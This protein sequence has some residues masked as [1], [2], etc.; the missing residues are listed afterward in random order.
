M[1]STFIQILLATIVVTSFSHDVQG[2]DKTWKL[3]GVTSNWSSAGNWNGGVPGSGDRALIT[4][5]DGAARTINYN[6]AG[7]PISLAGTI[8]DLTGPGAESTT[9]AIPANN[10]TTQYLIVGDFGRAQVEQT[11][12]AVA[13]LAGTNFVVGNQAGSNGRYVLNGG[14]VNVANQ[15][16]LGYFGSGDL[17]QTNGVNAVAGN[18]RL[19]INAGSSGVYGMEGG[20]LSAGNIYIGENGAGT[21]TQTGGQVIVGGDAVLG[22]AS[23]ATSNYSISAGS[24]SSGG[25]LIVGGKSTATFTQSGGT[26]TTSGELLLGSVTA[27]NAEY[28]INSGAVETAALGVFA[29][30]LCQAGGSISTG[31]L[32]ILVTSA[33]RPSVVD[34]SGGQLTVNG[35]I[36]LSGDVTD[37]VPTLVIRNGAKVVTNDFATLGFSAAGRAQVNVR[38]AG[39]KLTINGNLRVGGVVGSP[40]FELSRMGDLTISQGGGVFVN[41][42]TT[43]ST[44]SVVALQNGSLM[45]AQLALNGGSFVWTGGELRV[46]VFQGSLTN[47]L[48]GRLAPGRAADGLPAI[49]STT[50]SGNYVQQLGATLVSEIG[51]PVPIT[52]FDFVDVAGSAQLGGL[53]EVRLL[54]GYIPNPTA[55]FTILNAGGGITGGFSLFGN[56]QRVTTADGVGSFLVNY[57]PSSSYDANKV[58]LSAFQLLQKPGDFDLDN[59][60]DGVDFLRWQRGQSPNPLSPS[61][62]ALW[63]ANFAT[64]ESAA[65]SIAEPAAHALFISAVL[66]IVC[67]RRLGHST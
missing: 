2:A 49:G 8:L 52:G 15:Q 60:V 46:D 48:G 36:S 33:D 40:P 28:V 38:E 58:V 34:V 9:L 6:Y 26:V 43:I 29:G 16:V 59:D 50:I 66:A 51:G 57:G 55:T 53:L 42:S 31:G 14:S 1:R 17:L 62:L 5:N 18:L 41:A 3:L 22:D 11:G 37:V 27:G 30:R 21:F 12:G 24:L 19:G 39:S 44:A 47:P 4:L 65:L 32:V 13:T 54:N 35:L 20:S 67:R 23:G 7:A 56:G 61:D 45:S 10:L 64:A 25:K 63:K